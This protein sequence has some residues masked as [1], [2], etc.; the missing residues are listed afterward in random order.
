MD[1]NALK[2]KRFDDEYDAIVI[3]AGMGGNVAGCELAYSG[4]KVLVLEQHNLPGGF[5]TSFVRGKYEFEGTLHEILDVGTIAQNFE[6]RKTLTRLGVKY[7]FE[8][9]PEAYVINIPR[10]G[11]NMAMPFGVEAYIDKIESVCPGNKKKLTRYFEICRQFYEGNMEV[12]NLEKVG[13]YP[14]IFKFMKK[15]PD[16]YKYMTKTVGEVQEEFKF[17]E[18]VSSILYAYWCYQGPHI[19]ALTFSIWGYMLYGYLY[20]GANVPRNRSHALSL[21]IAERSVELGAQ[22]EYNCK[23]SEIVVEDNKVVGVKISDGTFIKAKAVL[24]NAHP[25]NVYG[26]MIDAKKVP[27]FV[28]KRTNALTNSMSSIAIYIGLDADPEDMGI[29]SYEYFISDTMDTK[30]IY[31]SLY[32]LKPHPFLS[33]I[34]LD[35]CIPGAT[36]KGICQLT[37]SWL[38]FGDVFKDVKE[39]EYENLKTK[40]GQEM[41]DIFERTTGAKIRDHIQEVEMVTPITWNRYTGAYKGQVFGH[42]QTVLN[43]AAMRIFGG[44][45]EKKKDIQGLFFVG[46]CSQTTHGYTPMIM[47]TKGVTRIAEKYIGGIK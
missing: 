8:E 37:I 30:E 7:Y 41:I 9:V 13:K 22:I 28:K 5:A 27:K 33:A 31:D 39:E 24:S 17:D 2:I 15:Y 12:V 38:I 44:K 11:I 40:F 6:V 16:Y 18:K 26:R 4:K 43:S 47:L 46:G 42:A 21:A 23:V 10:L 45:L 3:G 20:T 36:G 35:K 32:T 34:C 25:E 29:D 1:E 14:N 19:D